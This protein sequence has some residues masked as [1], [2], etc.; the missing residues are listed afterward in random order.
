MFKLQ[1]I[2]APFLLP[3]LLLTPAMSLAD[4]NDTTSQQEDVSFKVN[5]MIELPKIQKI[6]DKIK[7]QVSGYTNEN[8]LNQFN[9]IVLE[10]SAN[11]DIFGQLLI[12]K[13]QQIDTQLAVL[14]PVL[15]PNSGV[16]EIPEVT[17]KRNAL[18]S[19]KSK[20]DGQI[21]QADS[22]KKSALVLSSQI[23][24]LHRNLL[25]SQLTFNSGSILGRRFWS[26]VVSPSNLD[27]EKIGNFLA[28]LQDTT[29]FSWEPGWRRG[30]VA[31]LMTAMLVMMIGYCY[32]E[33]F[34]TWIIFH[35]MPKGRLRH[36]FLA[37]AIVLNILSMVVL[38]FN[39][40]TLALTRHNEVSSDVRDFFEHLSQSSMYCGLI[41]GLGRAFLLTRCPSLRLPNIS[42][43]VAL[44]MK[45][46]PLIITVLVFIFQTVDAFNYTLD[47]SLNTT[48]FTNG[49]TALLIGSTALV[50]SMLTNRVRR[51]MVQVNKLPDTRL[52]LVSII[53]MV[54]I[55]TA[56][57]ILIA[58]IIGYV[59]LARF[60]GYELIWCGIV[61]G[62]YY[63]LSQLI[64]DGCDSLCLKQTFTN[65]RIQTLLNIDERH[66]Q[67]MATLLSAIV[68]TI[69]VCFV[70]MAL[71]NGTFASSTPIELIQKVSEFWG[72]KGLQS[73][74]ILPEHIVNAIFCLVVGIYILR[75]IRRWLDKDFLPQT[76]MEVGMRVSLVMLFSNI[77]YVLIIL[78]TLSIMGLQ[79]NKLAWIVSAL[80]VGIG[81]GLQEIVKN[82]VSGLILLTERPIKVGDLVSISGIEG[83][84]RR[85]NV[86]AT[87]I[88]LSDKSTVIVPNSHLISQNVRNASMG[89]AQGVVVIILTFPLDINLI[90]VRDILLQVYQEN[91]RIL[92]IPQPSVSFKDLTPNGIV[93]SVTGNVSNQ[94]QI[95]SAKS[96]L[97]FDILRRIRKEGIVLSTPQ[98]MIIEYRFPPV[99]MEN[100]KDPLF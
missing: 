56:L 25:K 77:G 16:K 18:K 4:I 92:K 80:S 32:G 47:I 81:F 23:V 9:E 79:W 57:T 21:N 40:I 95:A 62:S 11:A 85:I 61:F 73:L 88:Q 31:W 96:S 15:K 1:S 71:L 39:Y 86:R 98:K 19:Q 65:K 53:Q 49:L 89:N 67:Q 83:D 82:F 42:N 28:E 26:P 100:E 55:F 43:E 76:T 44:M 8:Q 87:E 10:L 13:R 36:S 29:S 60:L 7:D 78:L 93:L 27:G 41:A 74:R 52:T 51:R 12:L 66:L 91:E 22:I 24:K 38:T 20:L 14:G 70:I 59:T 3:L 37:V 48:V 75:L 30:T 69:L 94:R 58:L 97:L 2:L 6:L 45:P 17:S 68:K 50:I 54:I 84:I 34:L 35:K 46:L 72:G 90:L 64:K 99:T 33:V 5:T 63:F